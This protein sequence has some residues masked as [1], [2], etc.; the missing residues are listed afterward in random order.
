M[1]MVPG[2]AFDLTEN[3]PEDDLPWDFNDEKGK[4]SQGMDQDSQTIV[5]HREPYVCGVEPHEQHQ[6]FQTAPRE[7]MTVVEYGTMHLDF[8]MELYRIQMRTVLYFLHEH[9]AA[10]ISWKNEAVRKI[11]Q[12]KGVQA[13]QG[14]MCQFGM[15]QWYGGTEEAVRK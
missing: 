11:A 1:R 5:T 15:K 12:A 10:A 2:I 6:L 14:V 4:E 9:P 3:D 13:F 8:C 7:V